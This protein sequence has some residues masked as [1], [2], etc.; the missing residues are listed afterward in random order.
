MVYRFYMLSSVMASRKLI[1]HLTYKR[2]ENRHHKKEGMAQFW[3][4][5]DSAEGTCEC[6]S[7]TL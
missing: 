2:V 7:L 5:H 3:Q 1:S 4:C 6:Y